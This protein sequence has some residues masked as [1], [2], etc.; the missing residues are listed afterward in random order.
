MTYDLDVSIK[1]TEHLRRT[2]LSLVGG[3]RNVFMKR[4]DELPTSKHFKTCSE[5]RKQ[6]SAAAISRKEL[7]IFCERSLL[8]FEK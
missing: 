6:N 1:D 8:G 7:H 3:T 2:G 4:D 5:P